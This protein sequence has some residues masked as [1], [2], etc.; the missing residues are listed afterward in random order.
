MMPAMDE[1]ERCAQAERFR[2]HLRELR[3]RLDPA[4]YR[5]LLKILRGVN[6]ALAGG[7]GDAEIDMPAAEQELFTEELQAELR[8][9][10]GMLDFA[11]DSVV[12]DLGEAAG[13]GNTEGRLGELQR[14]A[15]RREVE[16]IA[17]VSGMRP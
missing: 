12:I 7:A 8:T 11:E 5:L 3:G 13:T 10:L 1:E 15:D 2:L 6:D 14:A 16:C 4:S 9:A 17:R